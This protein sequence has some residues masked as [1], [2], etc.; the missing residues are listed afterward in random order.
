MRRW[1]QW[2]RFE[3]TSLSSSHSALKMG[4]TTNRKTKKAPPP[5]TEGPQLDLALIEQAVQGA[6]MDGEAARFL[7]RMAGIPG[8]SVALLGGRSLT[9]D[10]PVFAALRRANPGL[11]TTIR[12]DA[13]LVR[14]SDLS[15]HVP[16]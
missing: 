3:T 5:P 2:G 16:S 9:R 11:G 12:R 6:S 1:A 7:A 15:F 10:D 14:S 8:A 4:R 13:H